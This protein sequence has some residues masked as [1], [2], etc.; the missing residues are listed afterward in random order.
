MKVL[1]FCQTV[2][3]HSKK[4]SLWD[5]AKV[6]GKFKNHAKVVSVEFVGETELIAIKTSTKTYIAEGFFQHNSD[7][8]PR[9]T[10][11]HGTGG[12]STGSV[13]YMELINSVGEVI[14]GGGGR[15]SALMECLNIDHPDII[16]FIDKK[17]VEKVEK[18]HEV[19]V[20]V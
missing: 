11:I 10:P 20:I 5:G 7:I 8:R 18:I 9:G 16:E 1:S 6:R 3:I 2:R 4:E 19:E 12:T 13:S 17:F 14:K 15:R